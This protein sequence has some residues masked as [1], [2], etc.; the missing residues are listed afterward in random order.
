MILV[1][2]NYD[3]FTYNL[4]QYFG[5]LGAELCVARNDQITLN[6][7]RALAPSHI[8]ISPGPGTPDDSGVSLEVLRE[9][10]PSLPMLGVCLGHQAIGQVFGGV[11]KRAPYLMHGKTSLIYHHG[12]DVFTGLPTPFEATRYHSLIVEESSLPEVLEVTARTID[13]EIMGL[14]H[15]AYPVVGVQFH[16]ESILTAHGK[17]ML[18]NFLDMRVQEVA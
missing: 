8:V 1:I 15:R 2:D 6:E 10:G 4:V 14:R 18:Q 5:E 9:L 16:P 11:V 3:S 13:G 7:I 17:T 12:T